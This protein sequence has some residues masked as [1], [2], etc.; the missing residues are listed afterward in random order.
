[1]AAEDRCY[2]FLCALFA[3]LVV[4]GNLIYQKFVFLPLGFYT[5]QV[6]VGV[7]LYPL[8]FL[9]TDLVAE[10][11]GRERAL[12][13][14]RLGLGLNL[15]VALLVGFAVYLE[16][17]PWSPLT[18]GEFQKV[19]GFYTVAFMGSIVAS[20]ISQSVDVFVYLALRKW[21][22]GRF[23]AVRNVASTTLSLAV[24]T[25]IV[26]S[27]LVFFG[28]LPKTQWGHLILQSYGFKFCFALCNAPFFLLCVRGM[29][30]MGIKKRAL[31]ENAPALSSP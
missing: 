1:M 4:T 6:S 29:L 18:H 14:V 24:D 12:F 2:V 30:K 9:I 25:T 23:L 21:T 22:Q 10:F 31:S 28:A 20:Y 17:T 8:T 3:V 27:F 11:Y 26:V 19:F 13:S 7:I 5:F 16:A 15:L